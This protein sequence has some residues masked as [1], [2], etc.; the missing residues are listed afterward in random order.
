[1]RF[2]RFV[3]MIIDGFGIGEMPDAADFGDVGSDT[4]GNMLRQQPVRVPNLQRLGIANIRP[5]ENLAAVADPAGAYGRGATRSNGKDTATGH[6]EMAGILTDT[7]FPTYSDGFPPQVIAAFEAAVGR[8]VIGNRPASG[9]EIIKE[10][11]AEH[12]ATGKLIV[13]TSAD[14]VFQIAAHEQVVPLPEL[15]RICQTARQILQG[16]DRVGRV[17][18]RP[19]VGTP[20]NFKRTTNRHDYAVPP[21]AP[22][23]LDRMKERGLDVIGIGKIPDIYCHMGVTQEVHTV[24]NMDGVDKTLEALR[25]PSRGLIFTNLVDTDTLYGHR[26]DVPGYARA[27]EEYDARLPEV[28]AAMQDDEC[29]MITSDHGNDPTTPSTDHSRE[30]VPILAYHRRMARGVDL[31]IRPTLADIGQ[32]IAENF[33]LRIGVGESFLPELA[34]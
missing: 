30:Y 31:G 18:A 2:N 12:V 4:F 22:T 26:N 27:L 24:S 32:T 9:T 7:P 14:S 28:Y 15:Y 11:G 20:G 13:Y 17:I 25:A 8:Q 29:L 6:W 21:P 16:P 34:P 5:L 1:M 19:F 10:L 33:G 3:L 23:L